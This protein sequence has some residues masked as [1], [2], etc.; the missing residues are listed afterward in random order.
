MGD[1]VAGDIAIA[2]AIQRSQPCRDRADLTQAETAIA[3][4]IEQVEQAPTIFSD[5]D[6]CARRGCLR[7]EIE[8]GVHFLLSQLAIAIAVGERKYPPQELELRWP[9]F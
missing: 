2:I 8:V 4:G 6:R 7:L 9:D 5:G 1:F 3:I